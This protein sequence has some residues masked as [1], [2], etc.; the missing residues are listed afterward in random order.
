MNLGFNFRY[1]RNSKLHIEY[2][3]CKAFKTLNY[4]ME[5]ENDFKLG[6]SFKVS[7]CSIVQPIL[8]YDCIVWDSYT[9]RDYLQLEESTV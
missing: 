3:C 5:L 4:V 8:A 7:F 6:V 1:N 2:A 9:A